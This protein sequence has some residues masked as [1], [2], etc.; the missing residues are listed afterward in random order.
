[1]IYIIFFLKFKGPK[2][3]LKEPIGIFFSRWRANLLISSSYQYY[4]PGI[5]INPKYEI[6]LLR[7]YPLPSLHETFCKIFCKDS[8]IAVPK[9]PA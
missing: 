8:W 1:M 3:N 6:T 5:L 7:R 2:T 9:S 4:K